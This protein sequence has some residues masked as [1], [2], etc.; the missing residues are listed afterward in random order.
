MQGPNRKFTLDFEKAWNTVSWGFLNKFINDMVLGENW[1]ELK[2]AILKL[3]FVG[4]LYVSI[5]IVSF[6][7]EFEAHFYYFVS[8]GN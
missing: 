2:F 7:E 4:L 6:L 8:D 3:S 5:R 1:I